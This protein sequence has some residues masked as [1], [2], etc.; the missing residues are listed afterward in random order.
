MTQ[1]HRHTHAVRARH[2][3]GGIALLVVLIMVLL[4]TL[5][6]L[7][8]VR[9]L[10]VEERM[11]SNSLDRNLAMQSAENVLRYAEGIAQAQSVSTTFNAGFTSNSNLP[12]GSF[13]GACTDNMSDPS[14][15][16]SGL[17]SQPTPSCTP[18]WEL[19]GDHWA[20]PTNEQV[21]DASLASSTRPKYIIEFLGKNFACAPNDP[22][23]KYSCAQYRITVT[24]QGG[25]DRAAV[26]LQSYYLAQPK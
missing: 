1:H 26:Q 5:A 8:A 10:V 18:R 9:T 23:D 3:Q 12:Y 25:A 7:S 4:V 24:T 11:A 2:R 16:I 19:A 6:G 13:S 15:C 20:T 21:S 22:D 14:P 17:C